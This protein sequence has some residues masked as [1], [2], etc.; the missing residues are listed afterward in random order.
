MAVEKEDGGRIVATNRKA[1]HDY[2][3]LETVEAGIVLKGT[4]VKSL[5]LGNANLTESYATVKKGEIWLLGTH[6][7]PYERGSYSNVDPRRDRKL[8]LHR[9]EIRKLSARASETGITLIPL[10]LYF[11]S[12]N[13]AKV[14]LGVC[15]GKKEFDRRQDIAERDARRD[16][17]RKYAR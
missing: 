8:L 4:E 12:T 13:I 14:L 3:V 9:K 1:R 15:R 11:T 10:K 2:T 6:V 5:R 17:R 7:S 16:I